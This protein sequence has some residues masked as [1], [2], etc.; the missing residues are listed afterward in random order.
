MR[1]KIRKDWI[2][3]DFLKKIDSKEKRNQGPCFFF[4]VSQE[5]FFLLLWAGLISNGGFCFTLNRFFILLLPLNFSSF[6]GTF[7]QWKYNG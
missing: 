2:K 1:I 4:L 7:W 6:F 3:V 5:R